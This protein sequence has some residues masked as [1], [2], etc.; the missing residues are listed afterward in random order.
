MLSP[1]R[2]YFKV[3]LIVEHLVF[4]NQHKVFLFLFTGEPSGHFLGTIKIG[5]A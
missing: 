4:Y 5:E 2:F 1:E 3:L